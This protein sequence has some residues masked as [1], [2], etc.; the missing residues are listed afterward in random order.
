VNE[1]DDEEFEKAKEA[2]R[3]EIERLLALP[4]RP[5]RADAEDENPENGGT[6]HDD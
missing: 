1:K 6:E 5:L 4:V 3:K 2:T